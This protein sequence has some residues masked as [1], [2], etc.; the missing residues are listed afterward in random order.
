MRFRTW[1]VA[2]L[3]LGGLLLLVIVTVMAAANKAQEIYTQLEELNSHH[4]NVETKLRRLRSD[5]HLS[6]IFMRDYLLDPERKRGPQYRIRLTEFRQSNV[7]TLAELRA[8]MR[9]HDDQIVRLGQ[10]LDEYWKAFEPIF[11]WTPSEKILLSAK[12]LRTQ[13]LPRREAVLAIASEIETL[14]NAN[15]AVQRD[16]VSL[17]HS[18]FRQ[19][20]FRLLGGSLLLGLVVALTAVIRL[21]VLERRSEDERLAMEEAEQ[22]MRALSQQLVATQEEERKKLSRELHDQVGQML[23]ALRMELGRIDRLRSAAETGVGSAVAEC[24]QLVDNMVRTVRDLALGLRPSMLDDFGLEP[25][26]EWYVRD[27]SRRYGLTVELSMEGDFDDLPEPY[28]ICIYRAVQEALT[29]CVRHARASHVGVTV[30][31]HSGELTVS[32]TDDGVGIN[33]LRR[34][35]GLGLRG[36]EERVRELNGAVTIRSSPGGGTTLTI[37][38]PVPFR[39]AEVLRARAAG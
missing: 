20:L 19:D 6:G 32:V 37:S 28:R 36:I 3:G 12:F 4:R 18:E 8:L 39:T 27:V 31:E 29:N 38:L 23:T 14:N 26:L 2:A 35:D 5:V 34:A 25:A 15:H 24:R 7:T 13:V 10:Q 22:R 33:P 21:R 16:G 30:N 1:P 9:G 11:D 17:K